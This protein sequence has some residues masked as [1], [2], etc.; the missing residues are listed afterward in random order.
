VA[1]SKLF[2]VKPSEG[3]ARTKREAGWLIFY[4][5]ASGIY[6]VIVFSGVLLAV[7]DRF[8]IIGIVMAVVCLISWVTVPV[9]RFV[10]Y[11]A[12]SPKL[13]RV[14][15]RAVGVSAAG[16]AVVL[17]LLG[18]VPFPNSFRA[19]GVLKAAERTEV[20][21]ETAGTVEALLVRP[22]DTV[23]RGQPILKLR[24]RE[25]DLELVAAR[26]KL[27]EVKARLL[28]A[29]N[30]DSADVKPLAQLRDSVTDRIA[31]LSADTDHLTIIA[32]HDGVWVAPGVE[33]FVGR[34][35]PRG[36]D[37]GMLV[38][39]AAFEFS[40]TVMQEDVDAVFARKAPQAEVRLDGDVATE[41]AVRDWRVIPGGQEMLPSAALGWS[42]GGEVSVVQG[43]NRPNKAAEPFFSVIGKLDSDGKVAL[44]DGRLGKI[45]FKLPA[46]PLMQRWARRLW[47]LFQKRY[48]I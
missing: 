14:R 36:G 19:P 9:A 16:A 32:R 39:P 37:L 26:A 35:V 6:R 34:W 8:L 27:E 33:E 42:A 7:A 38:N 30:D 29:M 12:T 48:Q 43:D 1:E 41:L 20:A 44:L 3:P 23:K 40:A 11:L 17:I 47:Q 10:R 24:N 28:K 2:G 46:E 21:N 18:V 31:K 5:I 4:G 45:R 25:L 15:S 22:G 13:D